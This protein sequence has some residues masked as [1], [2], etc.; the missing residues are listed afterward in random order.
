MSDGFTFKMN[1]GGMQALNSMGKDV[2]AK[3]TKTVA[4]NAKVIEAKTKTSANMPV[5]TGNLRNSITSEATKEVTTWEIFDGTEYG[6]FQELGTSRGIQ[7]HHFLGG[8]C[9]EQ[10]DKF[11]EE[12]A[13]AL[14]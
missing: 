12:V 3:L 2:K 5:D 1:F 6:V 10:A 7:A 11:F 14:K 8:A 4:K 9:E 13:E